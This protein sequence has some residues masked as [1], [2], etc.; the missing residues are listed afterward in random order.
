MTKQILNT[1]EPQDLVNSGVLHFYTVA[2]SFFQQDS[3]SDVPIP[4]M[5]IRPSS[6]VQKIM[7]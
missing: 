4:A 3:F 1:L 5:T 6:A 2:M 7:R